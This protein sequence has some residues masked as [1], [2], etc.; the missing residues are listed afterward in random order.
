MTDKITLGQLLASFD[1]TIRRHAQGILKRL[2]ELAKEQADPKP[3]Q[4]N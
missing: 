1:E 3:E 2:I 4:H